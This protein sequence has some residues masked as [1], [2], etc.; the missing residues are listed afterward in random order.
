MVNEGMME[1]QN[2][3]GKRIV[4]NLRLHTVCTKLNLVACMLL[5]N[6]L[7]R[8]T[9]YLLLLF[10]NFR[11]IVKLT[12]KNKIDYQ[13]SFNSM[14]GFAKKTTHRHNLDLS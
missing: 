10:P 14:L 13:I 1:S 4:Q 8:P 9:H 7:G 11:I 5:V 3:K 2:G 6:G 12:N